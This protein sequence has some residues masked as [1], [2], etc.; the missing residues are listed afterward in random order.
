[1]ELICKIE[2]RTTVFITE[3]KFN[4]LKNADMIVRELINFGYHFNL[5]D[6]GL[7]ANLEEVISLDNDFIEN[8]E[9][10]EY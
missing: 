1:M 3:I 8:H 7:F 9:L 2:N 5:T 10:Y 6:Q 4:N